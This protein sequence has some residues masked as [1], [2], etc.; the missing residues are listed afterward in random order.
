MEPGVEG[1]VHFSELSWT[2]RI[3]KPSEVFKGPGEDIEAV[4][5]G[6]NQDEQKISLG[7]RQLERTH[8]FWAP[9]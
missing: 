5:F 7:T 6:I 1:L 2:K 9:G 3:N 8:G 4:V